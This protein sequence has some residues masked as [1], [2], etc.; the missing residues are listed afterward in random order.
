MSLV[1]WDD[2]EPEIETLGPMSGRWYDLGTAAGSRFAGV[3]RA[4]VDPGAQPSPAHRHGAEEELFYVL[5]G[6]GLSWQDGATYEIRAGDAILYRAAEEAHTVV[7][8]EQGIDLLTFGP[9][10]AEEATHLPR[11][12][13]L[14]IQRTWTEAGGGDHPWEREAAAGGVELPPSPS[15]WPRTIAAVADLEGVRTQRGRTDV[16]RRDIGGALGAETTGMRHIAIAPGAES[17]PPHC[18][19]AEEE[20]FVML[21]GAGLLRL[22]DEEH[23]VRAGHVLSRPAG[24]GVAHSFGAGDDGLAMLAWGTNDPRDLCW[25]PRSGK[26]LVTGLH[27][28]FR[29]EALDF[30]DGE[31]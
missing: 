6:D 31:A 22:G 17:Y 14:R 3:V 15:P 30:W 20:L 16:V 5:G 23:P 8:G 24:T 9:R 10:I 12:G 21:D 18:H 25:Y 13:V 4:V 26:V 1:H 2:V 28:V 29:P 27:L 11:A 19:S 7:A